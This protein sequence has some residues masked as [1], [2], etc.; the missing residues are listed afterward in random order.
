MKL[1]SLQ[2][3]AILKVFATFSCFMIQLIQH[4][5]KPKAY[6]CLYLLEFTCLYYIKMKYNTLYIY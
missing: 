3:D 2:E 5:S 1:I 6:S 4:N